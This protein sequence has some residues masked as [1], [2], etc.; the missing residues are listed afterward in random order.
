MS[1]ANPLS[2]PPLQAHHSL[3]LCSRDIAFSCSFETTGTIGQAVWHAVVA[4]EARKSWK[5]CCW[6]RGWEG[7]VFPSPD[8]TLAVNHRFLTTPPWSCAWRTVHAAVLPVSPVCSKLPFPLLASKKGSLTCLRRTT[9]LP[10]LRLHSKSGLK[11]GQ[12]GKTSQVF[13]SWWMPR[14][15]LS[16]GNYCL[17]IADPL[18]LLWS[19]WE[20]VLTSSLWNRLWRKFKIQHTS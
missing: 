2:A 11:A 12:G 16:L 4:R 8:L 5:R 19:G 6:G 9:V 13:S 14:S 7:R 18:Q 17:G 20:P 1:K 10:P 3:F 15:C